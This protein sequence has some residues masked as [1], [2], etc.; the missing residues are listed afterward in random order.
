[1]SVFDGLA[2]LFTDTFGEAV[3]YTPAAT[4][5]PVRINAIWW[6]S[7][8]DVPLDPGIAF[9]AKKTELSLRAADIAN[10]KEGDSAKRISDGKV[11]KIT[12]PILPDGKGIIRC[13]LGAVA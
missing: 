3:D 12:T 7:S 11:M 8:L 2:D 9:D 10:P 13:N 6:E 4:G 1:M 5:V